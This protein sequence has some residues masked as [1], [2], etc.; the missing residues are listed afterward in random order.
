MS[1]VSYETMFILFEDLVGVKV[2]V[3]ME[4]KADE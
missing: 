4:V 1:T 2:E 3:K